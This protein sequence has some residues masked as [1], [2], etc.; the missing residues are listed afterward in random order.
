[1]L[2]FR[3]LIRQCGVW[4]PRGKGKETEGASGRGQTRMQGRL[5]LGVVP[6]PAKRGLASACLEGPKLKRLSWARFY[7]LLCNK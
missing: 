7:I 2:I 1:M 5:S 6:A 4:E 3:K